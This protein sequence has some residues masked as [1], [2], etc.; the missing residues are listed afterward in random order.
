M[1]A[2]QFICACDN[3]IRTNTFSG[4]NVFSLVSDDELDLLKEP[5]SSEALNTLW[6]KSQNLVKCANCGLIYL[7]DTDS[8]E[9]IAYK[10]VE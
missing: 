6:F 10:K 8:G 1:M 7:H 3:R 4:N 5:I 2:S 9:Y